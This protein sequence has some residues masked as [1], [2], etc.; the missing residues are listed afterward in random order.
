MKEPYRA[1]Q[2]PARNDEITNA[3]IF[4]RATSI[5]ITDAASSRS[6]IARKARP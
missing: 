6:R 2:I 5:P 3:Q 4:A 1:P